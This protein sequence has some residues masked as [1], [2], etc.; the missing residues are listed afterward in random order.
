MKEKILYDNSLKI[1]PIPYHRHHPPIG[2]HS[3]CPYMCPQCQRHYLIRNVK[4]ED[5]PGTPMIRLAYKNEWFCPICGHIIPWGGLHPPKEWPSLEQ[6]QNP[7]FEYDP[8]R[9][10]YFENI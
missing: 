2:V 4:S 1:S 9:S 3:P 8:K 6:I 7:D 5:V 10:T